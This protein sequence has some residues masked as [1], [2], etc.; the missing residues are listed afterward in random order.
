MAAFALTN[1]AA[2]SGGNH[3]SF[4]A[5]LGPRTGTVSMLRTEL[6]DTP[7]VDELK[8][9]ARLYARIVVAQLNSPT[10]VQVRNAI[11]AVSTSI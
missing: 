11:N 5:T 7:S 1:A 2:C 6:L 10:P 3:V 8:E 9:F 4:T